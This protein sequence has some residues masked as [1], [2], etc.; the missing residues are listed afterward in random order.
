MPQ[1]R[2]LGGSYSGKGDRSIDEDDGRDIL[3]AG[4]GSDRFFEVRG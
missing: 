3:T 2:Q 4:W 1:M